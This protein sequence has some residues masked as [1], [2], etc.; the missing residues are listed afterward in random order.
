MSYELDDYQ[1]M[2]FG[3]LIRLFDYYMIIRDNSMGNPFVFSAMYEEKYGM[4]FYF[5][6]IMWHL[7]FNAIDEEFLNHYIHLCSYEKQRGKI[8]H[9]NKICESIDND[10]KYELRK[11][12]RQ[13][14]GIIDIVINYLY[15]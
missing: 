8:D 1:Q 6:S 12:I 4:D 2:C 5:Y 3:R 10:I 13:E 15:Y 11:V 14:R 7:F 9:I